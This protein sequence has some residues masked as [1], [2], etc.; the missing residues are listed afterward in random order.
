MLSVPSLLGVVY[1]QP[2]DAF[3]V[4][5]S[6]VQYFKDIGT[7]TI[8]NCHAVADSGITI[9]STVVSGKIVKQWI[10]GGASGGSY[11]VTLT[12]TSVEGRVKQVEFRVRVKE[13]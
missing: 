9:A 6:F 4:G 5:I 2:A 11:K 13:I 8:D 10:S 1:K 3:D 7:D 12:M